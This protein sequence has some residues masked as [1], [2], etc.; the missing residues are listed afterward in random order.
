MNRAV[1][2]ARFSTDKQDP[3]SIA[4]QVRRC[5][6]YAAAE[7]M[8]VVDIYAD[9]AVSGTTVSRADLQRM[10]RDAR[11]KKFDVLLVDDF[12]RLSRDLVDGPRLVYHELAPLNIVTVDVAK[13][14]RSDSPGA[15]MVFGVAAIVSDAM[16]ET[17]RTQ[18]HRGLE[19]RALAGFATGGKT[20]GY[21]SEPES[22]PSDPEHPRKVVKIAPHEAQL[23]VRIFRMFVEGKS[24]QAIASLLNAE[25]VPAP[26]DGGK[27]NKGARGWGHTTIR[28]VLKNERYLGRTVWNTSRWVKNPATGKRKRLERPRSE[29]RHREDPHLRV[30]PDDLWAAAQARFNRTYTGGRSAGSGSRGCA[31]LF[32]GLMRCGTCLGSFGVVGRKVKAGVTYTS[33][34]CATNRSRGDAICPNHRTIS[35]ERLTTHVIAKLQEMASSPELLAEYAAHAQ[36]KVVE[37]QKAQNTKEL[38]ADIREVDRTVRTCMDLVLKMPDSEAA[39]DRLR[40]EETRLRALKARQSEARKRVVIPLPSTLQQRF[41]NMVETL[42]ANRERGRALLQQVALEPLV[43]TPLDGGAY[44]IRGLLD[45][46]L[47]LEVRGS[48]GLKMSCSGGGIARLPDIELTTDL[49]PATSSPPSVRPPSPR[50]ASPAPGLRPG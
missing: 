19:G 12:S 5:R 49:P 22:G 21:T 36:R 48:S 13:R 16:I 24:G 27:G 18:T 45:L 30:V 39:A 50:V 47:V 34:G 14:M 38:D 35:D 11:L 37:A 44:R 25:G 23:V 1:I 2:Y 32:S 31:S 29:W 7:D 33:L 10:L 41:L 3:A 20:L 17:I 6:E 8:N 42:R 15:R 26:H 4:D 46:D 28:A 9:Q 40:E 43:L